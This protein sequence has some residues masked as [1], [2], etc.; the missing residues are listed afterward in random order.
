[1][2]E[3]SDSIAFQTEL[4]AL[5]A[6]SEAG[7]A[8]EAGRGCGVVD[9]EVG[10]RAVRSAEA[11]REIR[12]LIENARTTVETGVAR[13]GQAASVMGVLD[14]SVGELGEVARQVAG[15]ARAQASGIDRVHVAAAELDR[16]Y[17]R[18]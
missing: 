8:G 6:A 12:T 11:S 2:H 13:V 3:T 14:A 4:R 17:E 5:S 7:R 9:D 10:Q 1:M 16:V 15:T 18:R